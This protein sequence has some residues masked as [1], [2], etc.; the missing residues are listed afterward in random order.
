MPKKTKLSNTEIGYM[1]R[2]AFNYYQFEIAVVAGKVTREQLLA[3]CSHISGDNDFIPSQVGLEDLQPRMGSFP[4]TDDHVWHEL[5]EVKPTRKS[6]TV[7]FNAEW[8]MNRFLACKDRWDVS[9]AMKK[10]GLV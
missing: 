7:A 3:G 2:D 6:P 10:L 8:L 9:K 5:L 1:Y 4:S